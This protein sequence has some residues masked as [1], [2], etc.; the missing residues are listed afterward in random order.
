M[1]QDKIEKVSDALA[2]AAALI[3]ATRAHSLSAMKSP[4]G[5]ISISRTSLLLYT[6]MVN[7][8]PAGG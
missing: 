3:L 8:H 5:V 4:V 1:Q 6:L 2:A 7:L